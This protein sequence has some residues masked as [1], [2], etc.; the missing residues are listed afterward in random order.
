ML[1]RPIVVSALV[2]CRPKVLADHLTCVSGHYVQAEGLEHRHVAI[3]Q[4][5]YM[6]VYLG[7]RGQQEGQKISFS[8]NTGQE[9]PLPE[10]QHDAGSQNR[11]PATWSLLQCLTNRVTTENWLLVSR[12]RLSACTGW[13]RPHRLVALDAHSLRCYAITLCTFQVSSCSSNSLCT[14]YSRFRA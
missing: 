13:V 4:I 12:H 14:V 7:P 6:N 10:N 3:H 5:Y 8:V 9:D 2:N 11:I 1:P